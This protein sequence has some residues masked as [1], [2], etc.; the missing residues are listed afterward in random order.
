MEKEIEVLHEFLKSSHSE[1]AVKKVA[2]VAEK[3]AT[4]AEKKILEVQEIAKKLGLELT[5]KPQSKPTTASATHRPMGP[6]ESG[7][8]AKLKNLE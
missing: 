3:V 7:L 6:S 5:F 2:Q 4:G 8:V 1:D